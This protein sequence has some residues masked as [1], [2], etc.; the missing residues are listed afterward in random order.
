MLM[1]MI[2]YE[3]F[4][5]PFFIFFGVAISSDLGVL[6]FIITITFLLD[7]GRAQTGLNFNTAYFEQGNF[8]S[9]RWAITKSYIRLW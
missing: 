8:V 5:V 6:E 9:S 7:I 4:A 1:G 3:S 2:V